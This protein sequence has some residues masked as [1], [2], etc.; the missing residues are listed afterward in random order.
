[1]LPLG[2]IANIQPQ[3]VNT[4]ARWLH[5]LLPDQLMPWAYAW[6][7]LL[8]KGTHKARNVSCHWSL[9]IDTCYVKYLCKLFYWL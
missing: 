6:K 2:A 7:S 5:N 9:S 3:F 4:D 8:D 1:M